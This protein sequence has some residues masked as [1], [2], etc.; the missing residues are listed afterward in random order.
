MPAMLTSTSVGEY[1]SKVI[2]FSVENKKG[3]MDYPKPP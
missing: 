3:G 1:V 2:A